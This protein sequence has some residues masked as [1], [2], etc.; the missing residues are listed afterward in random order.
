[1][2]YLQQN[3][4]KIP[5]AKKATTS[6]LRRISYCNNKGKRARPNQKLVELISGKIRM[7]LLP[8]PNSI[9][10]AEQD[11]IPIPVHT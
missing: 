2:L 4:D 6:I 1:M 11:G 9:H 5:A 7:N 8:V 3:H 10:I